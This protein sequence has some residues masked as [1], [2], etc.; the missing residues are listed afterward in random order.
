MSDQVTRFAHLH[1]H[2]AYSLLDGAARIKDLIDWVKQTSPDRPTVAMTDHGNMHGAVEFYKAASGAGV[3]PI[4]GFEAYVAPGSRFEKRRG[5]NKLDGGYYHLTLLAKDFKGYQN[6]CRLSSRA[7][8]EGFYMKPRIDLELL[9]EHS[10]GVI[11]LSG[12]L[13]AQ[14]PRAIL[15]LGP[16]E[17]ERLFKEHLDIFGS[18]F[19]V[20]LQNHGLE[21]QQQLNP[22]LRQ[23]ADKYGVGL[24]ATNDGHYVKRQDAHAHDVLLAIQTK[25][26]V[27]NE[28]RMRFP[29]DEFYVKSPSEMA[30]VIPEHDYPGAIDNTNVVADM[31]D[32]E[33]PIGNKRVYQMPELKLAQGRTLADQLRMDTY[34]GVLQR[35]PAMT[36]AVLRRYL[37]S[38]LQTPGCEAAAA[39]VLAGSSTEQATLEQVLLALARAGEASKLSE[40]ELAADESGN[41][42]RKGGY[43]YRHLEHFADV[44]V[45]SGVN[46]GINSGAN[47]GVDVGAED[48]VV[49]IIERSEYELGVI[50]SMGFADYYLIVADFINWAKDQDIAVGPGRGSG[51]GSIVA[52]S[53]RIT[54]IDPLYF[55]LLF[56]RFLNPE[57]I[58]MPDFDIDFSDVR[59]G[60]VIEYVRQRYGDDRVA[61]IAT[62]GTMASKA[63]VKDAARVL[64]IPYGES[65]KVSKLIPVVQ[66]RSVKIEDALNSVPE[67]KQLYDAGAN[68]YI[69]VAKSLEGLNR[70]ASVHAA[71]VVIARDPIQD[72]APVFRAG[73]GP[74]VVQYDMS[75]VEELGFIKMDFLGL[76]TLSFIEAAVR[77]VRESRG[78]ELD[79]DTFPQDDQLVF[80]LLSRGEAAGVF[81]FE[82]VGMIDT[83]KKLKPK[84]IQDLIAVTALYRPG[85]MEN[86]PAFIRRHHGLEEIDYSDFPVSEPLLKPILEET[87][88]F[89]VYQEHVMEIVRAVAGYSLGQADIMRR[90]MGKKKVEEMERQRAI[91][92]EG[93]KLNGVEAKESARIFDMLER[94]ANYG[95]P[96]AH[97]AAY[98]VISYQTAYLKAH[99]PV[100]FAAAL[101]TVERGDSDKVAHYIADAHHLGI[102]VLP[103]DI[104]LSRAD[105]TPVGDV[106]R[107]GL[108]GI[109]NVG[110][111]AVNHILAERERA[112][113]F[114]DIFDFCSRID[115]TLVNK[116]AVEFLVK[117]GS[118]DH[119]T[120]AADHDLLSGRAAILLG[121]DTA[122]RYGIAAREQEAQGQMGLFGDAVTAAPQL[123]RPAAI[124]EL[125]LLRFEKEALG[126]YL[127]A[128]PMASYPGLSEAASCTI[129]KLDEH[130]QALDAGQ[131]GRVKVVL[132]GLI[133]NVVKRPTRKG[134]MMAR[135]ELADESGSREVVAFSRRYD[136]IAHLL[137]EDM[138]AVLVAEVSEDGDATRLVADRLIRWDLRGQ[139]GAG[140]GVPEVAVLRFDLGSVAKHQLLELRSLLDDFSG[141]TP[142]RLEVKTGDGRYLYQVDS[143]RV[144][145]QQLDELRS[146]CPWLS[147]GLTID[148]Q[149][150]LAQKTQRPYGQKKDAP[151]EVPF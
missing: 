67:L 100:E 81:Q 69:D 102:E 147:A 86:I 9:R 48:E 116:R 103:P 107:F 11:A 87:Q 129:A 94:F 42:R 80:D 113:T 121:L 77:I 1:Q 50:I 8:L 78:I 95:F 141:R 17:G 106:V 23:F 14:I 92:V 45:N 115:S 84:R 72:L 5:S 150:L 59:R 28:N 120:G 63:A 79:P 96:R 114:K 40:A 27:A 15:D 117:A 57:R 56:E 19:F 62:F 3:K 143:V 146:A 35:Y 149:L 29:C 133:Q 137:E 125:E 101:L 61:H 16:E 89:P 32:L 145:E 83:L 10:Q 70:H 82:S 64:D 4:I 34:R 6:L 123:E 128:H 98:G 99:F 108:Y 44:G 132:A 74:V 52:Y 76:R 140:N 111:G 22:V 104:N 20:E 112:G 12:C 30:Q 55:N 148:R 138:P 60:E 85:P 131:G 25:E 58:S 127:S 21:E 119:L 90:A 31:I 144:D 109:K 2:T 124:D 110:E 139:E 135:F 24:V 122:I 47:S 7:Y 37:D 73:D 65:D 53:L 13:G 66:G 130:Y 118:F 97:A 51:A 151:V 105:F 88:G 38:A 43:R 54:N 71:G 93:A 26:M 134:S 75:S 39:A 36:E 126:I 136:E 41:Y 18:N 33:L 142:V 68:S 49:T 46:A 91:F